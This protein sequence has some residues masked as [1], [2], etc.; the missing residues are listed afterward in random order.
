MNGFR[1]YN[2]NKLGVWSVTCSARMTYGTHFSLGF[3]SFN[4]WSDQLN[5]FFFTFNNESLHSMHLSTHI[6]LYKYPSILHNFLFHHLTLSCSPFF[7]QFVYIVCP[8]YKKSTIYN[9]L[10]IVWK[11]KSYGVILQICTICQGLRV[12]S[13]DVRLIMLQKERSC[14]IPLRFWW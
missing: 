6:S 13:L 12:V 14:T 11:V 3:T 1:S 8:S 7:L 2:P 10:G 9:V 5:T 4:G